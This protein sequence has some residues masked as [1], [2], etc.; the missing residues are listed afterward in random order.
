MEISAQSVLPLGI[1]CSPE[2]KHAPTIT[3]EDPDDLKVVMFL[4]VVLWSSCVLFHG[5]VGACVGGTVEILILFWL[6][7]LVYLPL[8]V[9]LI[10]CQ[11]E[12]ASGFH[13]GIVC[14]FLG[15]FVAA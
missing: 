13:F 5:G 15:P 7:F 2:N 10:P 12:P 1:M 6:A 3:Q 9:N 14:I 4:D 8:Q 11:V